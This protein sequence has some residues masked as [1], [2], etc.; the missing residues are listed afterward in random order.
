MIGNGACGHGA[1]PCDLGRVILASSKARDTRSVLVLTHDRGH[2]MGTIKHVVMDVEQP[3][4][5]FTVSGR[6]RWSNEKIQWENIGNGNSNAHNLLQAAYELRS[7]GIVVMEDV[8]PF[9]RD[10]NGDLL[11]RDMMRTMLSSEPR[12]HGLVL[13][14]LEPPESEGSLPSI[15]ADRFVR[16]NVPHPRTNE[17]EIIAREEI[18]KANLGSGNRV[19]GDT[20]REAA[21]RMGIELVGLTQSAAR[22][23]VHDALAPDPMDFDSAY[24][25]LRKRKSKLFQRELSMRVLDD[26]EETPIGIPYLMNYIK[27]QAPRMRLSGTNRARGILLVGPPGTGKT[28]YSKAIGRQVGLPVVEFRISSLMNSL[29]GETERRF[30]KAFATLEAMA[31]NI[32]FIDEIEK[33]FGEGG[34]N[35]GGTMMRCTGSLLTWL[36][37]N[38]SP[39]YIVATCNSLKR[40]G[41][42]GKTMT[43]SERFDDAFFVDVPNID[44]RREMLERWLKTHV[45]DPAS[46]AQDIALITE[47]F[48]GADL[49]SLVKHAVAQAEH[50]GRDVTLDLLKVEAER[51]RMRAIALYDEFMELR[52]W[53]RMYCELAGPVDN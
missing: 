26:D 18:A 30:A 17:L 13:V 22:D 35:D 16:L 38:P 9:L 39:N 44:A 46:C 28:M 2:A 21:R 3:L 6:R 34:E 36:S 37:D 32:T 53:G 47:K 5:H 20:I 43:R 1:F 48:S 41:E 45:P 33:A 50:E 7:G 12:Q 31:P 25:V 24:Q 42:I 51:R 10:E 23:A 49:R 8:M 52:R 29:L 4:Y 14:F 27:L 11:A 19:D 40:M 15:L